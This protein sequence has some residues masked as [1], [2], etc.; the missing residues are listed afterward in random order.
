MVISSMPPTLPH[1]RSGKLNAI[2]VTTAQRWPSTPEFPTVAES[3]PGYDVELWFG[4][5]APKGTSAAIVGRLNAAINKTILEDD[6]QQ[7]FTALGIHATGG[8]P[9]QFVS[10]IRRDVERWNRVVQQ[11]GIKPDS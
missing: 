4:M 1:V 10:R 6:M 2:A 3:L 9:K 11:A 5:W 7:Q 8:E